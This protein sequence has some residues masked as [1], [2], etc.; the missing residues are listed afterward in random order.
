MGPIQLVIF[1]HRP[2]PTILDTHLN[3]QWIGDWQDSCQATWCIGIMKQP[4]G[5]YI[6]RRGSQVEK[7]VHAKGGFCRRTSAS[8]LCSNTC[9][10]PSFEFL[11]E[12]HISIAH[13]ARRGIPNSA[14]CVLTMRQVWCVKS[15]FV[16]MGASF[17]CLLFFHFK[18]YVFKTHLYKKKYSFWLNQ[19]RP[20]DTREVRLW[21]NEH[22]PRKKTQTS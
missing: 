15:S 20:W 8:F 16:T 1:D 5:S 18:S 13:G 19:N 17:R 11:S 14:W 4:S 9:I 3:T 2:P 12:F 7:C 10:S 22:K 6:E 21:T